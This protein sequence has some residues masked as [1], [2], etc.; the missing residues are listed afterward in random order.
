[1]VCGLEVAATVAFTYLPPILLKAGFA[2]SNM[3]IILGIGKFKK[4]NFNWIYYPLFFFNK[5][6]GPLIGM[7]TVSAVG[8]LSD[9]WN[10]KFG[11]RVYFML[12]FA[13]ILSLSLLSI[14]VG[15]RLSLSA[16]GV[17]LGYVC[18]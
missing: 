5:F 15:H 16:E 3:G 1:M 14:I 8:Q 6:S 18:I 11:Q 13:I 4:F 2:E 7:F 9:Y 17:S 12:M 10:N